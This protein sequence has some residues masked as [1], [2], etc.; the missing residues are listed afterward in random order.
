M[1]SEVLVSRMKTQRVSEIPDCLL[2]GLQ[3]SRDV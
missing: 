2:Y 3:L 1:N